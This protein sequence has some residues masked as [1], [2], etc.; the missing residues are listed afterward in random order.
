MR[1]VVDRAARAMAVLGIAVT[2]VGA[3]A[4]ANPAAPS[5]KV[6]FAVTDLRVGTGAVVSTAQFVSVN[7][8][9]WLYD[10]T[11]PEKK[12]DQFDASAPGRPFVFWLGAN[13][14][15]AGWDQ[16]IVGM[17]VGGLRRLQIPASLA[18]GRNGAGAAIP[19]NASLVFDIELVSVF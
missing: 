14:V 1:C 19:P 6:P 3:A 18:Y 16:G 9:G 12:G 2:L 17:R 10:G 15:I 5:V 13:Q 8:T 4:C 11:D 7:Y